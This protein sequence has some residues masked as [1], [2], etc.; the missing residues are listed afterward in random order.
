MRHQHLAFWFALAVCLSWPGNASS[1]ELASIAGLQLR[2]SERAVREH[3]NWQRPTT[4]VVRGADAGRLA[5]LQE[6]AEGIG[7][8]SAS[9][10]SEAMQAVDKAQALVGFCTPELVSAGHQLHWIQLPSAGAE[11]CV[12]IDDVRERDLV[13]TNMQ[14]IYGPEMADHVMA[15]LL[16]LTRGLNTY[17]AEQAKGEWVDRVPMARMWELQGKTML[18]VGLGG[19]GTE[20]ARRAKGFGMRVVATRNSSRDGP[21]FVDYVGLADEL[22]E[23]A[24]DSHVV[25][26]ATPLTP[27]T[28]GLFDEVFFDTLKSNAYFINVGRGRSVVTADMLEALRSGR[29]AGAGLDVTDPEPLP[30]GHPLWAMRNVIIT[31]HVSAHSDIRLERFWVLVRENL[32]RYVN[33]DPMLSVVGVARGY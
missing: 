25:V 13:V 32:R 8:I 29:L 23:L 15:M 14:R 18:V 6:A 10:H 11:Y 5:W 28:T 20:V 24:A 26:N 12:S 22:L 16:S 17:I 30:S 19:I 31:P 9:T 1:D 21:E 3:V 7:L 2:E 27:E 4:I 33:G